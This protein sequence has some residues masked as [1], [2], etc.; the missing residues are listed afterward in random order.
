MTIKSEDTNQFALCHHCDL[1][2]ELPAITS[3]T[4]AVCPRCN[5]RLAQDRHHMVRNTLIYSI[6][7]LCLLL[8]ACF[9][10]FMHIRVIGI[11]NQITIL[12]IPNILKQDDYLYLTVLF[13]LITLALPSL[14]L[15]I[16]ILLC[17]P[18]R[19]SNKLRR[20]LL[21][22]YQIAHHWCMPEIFMAGVLVSF[23]KLANYG[24]LGI[25]S[26]FIAFSLFIIFYLK[27]TIV[28]APRFIW[29]AIATN[30]YAHRTLKLGKSGISQ[31]IRLCLCCHAILPAEL[32]H[33]VR[34]KE[35]GQLRE[36]KKIQWTIAL[37]LTSI[38]LYIPANIYGVMNTVF[39]GSQS[40]STILDGVLY[41]WH[42]GDYPVALII[43]IA[44]VAIPV[45]KILSL[46]WLCIF[47]ILV[48]RKPF[49]D[50]YRMDRLYKMVEFIGR[51]SMIDI[52]VVTV[53]S[54]MIR[55]GELMAV[56]P[57]IGAI[58]FSAVV[59]VTMI[60][61][62]KYDPRLIWDRKPYYKS[63]QVNYG[64]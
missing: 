19:L 58:Y 3:K 4:K 48:K 23:V 6:C 35:R 29:N 20:D 12:D 13:V 38:I 43:F 14:L 32:V 49:K 47:A 52:F 51:W 18:L 39:L 2:C 17:S 30:N 44:S 42:E 10:I 40:S 64:K 21:K 1:L 7:A 46:G 63:V 41:M 59:I 54:A 25:N 50:C 26:A 34:C 56:S 55:N 8:L 31:G 24:D 11:T 37:L 27:S 9:F 22:L 15:L 5:T 61:A 33:C 16:Q 28:F 62:Q 53:I 57:D 36:R 60:A 45:L